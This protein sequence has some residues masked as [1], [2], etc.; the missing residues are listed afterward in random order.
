MLTHDQEEAL[1]KLSKLRYPISERMD[2]NSINLRQIQQS[3]YM[4]GALSRQDYIEELE[5][6]NINLQ[7]IINNLLSN[8]DIE[9]PKEDYRVICSVKGYPDTVFSFNDLPYYGVVNNIICTVTAR[10]TVI[11]QNLSHEIIKTMKIKVQ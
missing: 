2:R 4:E 1:Q 5:T 7:D 8:G 3:A 10:G 9:K 6:N 11:F